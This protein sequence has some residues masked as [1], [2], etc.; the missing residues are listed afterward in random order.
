V[1][2][3]VWEKAEEDF[4]SKQL[5]KRKENHTGRTRHKLGKRGTRK[6]HMGEIVG[7]K[8]ENL[9]EIKEDIDD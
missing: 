1:K 8:G 4:A 2:R 5:I 3:V 9:Q 7:K 6:N